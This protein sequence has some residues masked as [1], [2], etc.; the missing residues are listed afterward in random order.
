MDFWCGSQSHRLCKVKQMVVLDRL[1]VEK[2]LRNAG[3][4]RVSMEAG[5]ELTVLL[6]D[7]AKEIIEQAILISRHARKNKKGKAKTALTAK[8]ILLGASFVHS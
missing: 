1:A 4:R 2:I 5:D 8:D 7:K 6:E 3:A